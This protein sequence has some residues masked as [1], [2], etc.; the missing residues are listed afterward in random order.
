MREGEFSNIAPQLLGDV[1]ISVETAEKE[2]KAAGTPTETRFA[3][4][5]IHGILHLFG[6]DHEKNER[7]SLRMDKKSAA[8][9]KLIEKMEVH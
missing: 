5:L 3:Q 6:Y 1:V 7:E 8:L 2:G 4:L 9:L